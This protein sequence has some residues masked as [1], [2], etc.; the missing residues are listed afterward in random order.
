[1]QQRGICTRKKVCACYAQEIGILLLGPSKG[2]TA[3]IPEVSSKWPALS[4][5]K[6]VHEGAMERSMACQSFGGLAD[7]EMLL[8]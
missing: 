7:D 5:N 1:M 3:P 8:N 4:L 2:C 6:E